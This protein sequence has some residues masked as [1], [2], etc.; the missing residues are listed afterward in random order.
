MADEKK[1]TALRERNDQLQSFIQ[2]Q[3]EHKQQIQQVARQRRIDSPD[4]HA[5]TGYP[6]LNSPTREI[7]AAEAKAAKAEILNAALFQQQRV[8]AAKN[9]AAGSHRTVNSSVEDVIRPNECYALSLRF[10]RRTTLPLIS[11]R[12]SPQALPAGHRCSSARHPLRHRRLCP[13]RR[14]RS[15]GR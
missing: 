8:K 12:P 3:V 4:A 11:T 2:T 13:R 6:A 5:R 9:D 15:A 1:A 7:R 14:A 10:D